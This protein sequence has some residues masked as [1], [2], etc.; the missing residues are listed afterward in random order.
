V[1]TH[2]L[3]EHSS[4]IFPPKPGGILINVADSPSEGISLFLP[5]YNEEENVQW[6]V[7]R[8]REALSKI[9]DRWEIIVVDDG[10]TDA[11]ASITSALANSDNRIRL[12]S[13]EKNRGFGQVLM[14]GI[15][16]SVYEWIFYTDCDGQFDLDE[17][18]MVWNEREEADI[19]SGFRRRR[20]DPG[21]RLF[22]SLAYTALTLII[23]GKGFKD[24]D[25]SFKLYRKAIFS[26]VKPRS[27]CGVADFEILTLARGFGYRVRQVPVSHFPR[28]AGTVS[29]ESVR[30]GFLAWVRLSALF[31]MFV[32]LL[33]FRIRIFRG[34]VK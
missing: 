17:L 18:Q 34:K 26:R 1:L 27:T 8:A 4:L 30:K 6:M 3:G 16:A 25:A 20:Q 5:A 9:T 10:S 12:V 31:E 19:V 28:R 15:A 23:F 21:M 2:W 24:C 32:Q 11:T 33:A 7:E 14:T 22:Y 29:F 13:H